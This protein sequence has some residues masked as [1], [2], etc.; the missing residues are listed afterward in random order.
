MSTPRRVRSDPSV[1]HRAATT[2]FEGDERF[3]LRGLVGEGGMGLVYQAYDRERDLVVALKTLRAIDPDALYRLKT[4]FR[5]RADLEHR[6]L[7]RLGELLHSGGHWFFTMELV[8]GVPFLEHV[9][10][11]DRTLDDTGDGSWPG[12]LDEA[13]LR[14]SLRQLAQGLDALHRAGKVHRDLKPS[15]VLITRK[16]RVVVLDFGLIR[17]AVMPQVSDAAVVGTAAYMAP[18]QAMSPAVSPAADCYSVG[19]MLFE[20]LTGRLPFEGRAIEILMNKQQRAAP[21]VARFGPAPADLARLCDELL[22]LDPARRPSAADIVARLSARPSTRAPDRALPFV[23]RT[24]ELARLADALDDV[25]RGQ[26]RTVCIEGPSGIGKSALV[27]AFVEHLDREHAEVR[28]LSGRCYERESVPFKGIDG[29]VDDLVRDLLR[30]DPIDVAFLLTPE[31]DAL[32]R[33]FPVLRRVPAIARLSVR[34]PDSP[35]ELRARAF[36]GLRHLLTALALQAPL[37]I[38]I[39][40]VQWADSDSL[41]LLGEVLEPSAAPP[42]LLILTRRL[43]ATAPPLALPGA[44]ATMAL[45]RLTAAEGRALVTLLAPER[46]ADADALVD[47]ADGHPLFLQQLVRHSAGAVARLDQALW[48]QVTRMEPAS[49]RVLELVAVA[50]APV[51]QGVIGS[52]LELER[53]ALAKAIDTLRASWL[54]RTGGTRSHDP[55]EPYHDR[56]RDAVTARIPMARRRRYHRWLAAALLA[57]PAVEQAPLLVV[58]HLEAAGALDHAAEL[59]EV[60]AQRACD[61]LAFELAA[62]LWAAALRMGR[63]DDDRRRAI[64]AARAE[65]LGYAGRGHAA[66]QVYLAAAEGAEPEVAA[67]CRRLAAHELLVSGH[68]VEGRRLLDEVLAEIGDY[69]PRTIGAAKRWL[70]WLWLRTLVRGT[71]FTPRRTPDAPS[72]DH[73]RLDV[74]RTASLGLGMVEVIAGGA[75]QARAL[76]VALR[77]GDRRRVTY[78]LAY[79]AMYLGSSGVRVGLAR[80]AVTRAAELARECQSQFLVAWA[81]AAE[82]IVEF[83]AGRYA[84]AITCLSEAEVALR[85]RSVGTAA[86][87]NHVRV[88]I[89]MALRRHNDYRELAVRQRDYLRDAIRR[90][91]RYAAASFQWSSNVVWLAADD[92]VRARAELAPDIWSAP[93]A[94]L[95]LQHWFRVRG[96]VELALYEDDPAAVAR[97]AHDIRPFAGPA[98]A[99]VEAVRTET[100]YLVARAAV[101]AGDAAAARKA[102]GPLVRVRTPYIRVFVRLVLAAIEVMR[103]RPD[104]ARALLRGAAADAEA[105][106]MPG[107]AAL[108]RRRLAELDGDAA[109]LADA[110]LALAARGVTNPVA[111]ARM[112]ATWPRRR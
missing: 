20:A 98:F 33:T 21:P 7:V 26:P 41:A 11:E 95:H 70:A 64:L 62:D 96:L 91:D 14:E 68:V 37:V 48:A 65:A 102:I 52:A 6:N 24:G 74:Y 103:D 81:R 15:N 1:D 66:A 110:D 53:R 56:V 109:S 58:R 22:A 23:G 59:A 108:A 99:H 51:P 84:Y 97:A 36:R 89:V 61:A 79:H 88:F 57:S 35:I 112:F 29:V 100:L 5:A 92:P 17:D 94:G 87:I 45:E 77:L 10:A 85:E 67:R 105:V 2:G 31:V 106:D 73:L 38:V 16:G 93:E 13:A 18:E 111:F 107:T 4:E 54:V 39:D 71:H 90:G 28:V 86:E 47:D 78:A 82:G 42:I 55:I 63:H 75:F 19:V 40:D 83:F 34:K 104:R 101:V 60:S 3:E 30:R 9:R 80:R 76:L 44:I 46:A 27:H 49:R 69:N 25:R 50:G 8:D 12:R 43:A 32:A 72:I